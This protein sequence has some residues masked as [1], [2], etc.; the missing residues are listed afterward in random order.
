MRFKIDENLS[1]STKRTIIDSGHDC[2]SVYDEEIAGGSDK[3]LIDIC[4]VEK[5]H[6]VTLDLDFAD[7]ISYPPEKY[8]GI[9]IL[10]LSQQDPNFVNRAII[11]ALPTIE[12][13]EL[14]GRLMIVGDSKIRLR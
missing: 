7:I 2:H 4:H 1:E 3:D 12:N 14:S 9:V 5:R 10:R 13:L 8:S 6:L 11:R